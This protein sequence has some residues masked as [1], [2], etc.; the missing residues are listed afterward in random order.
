MNKKQEIEKKSKKKTNLT[1]PLDNATIA[2]INTL[3]SRY[4]TFRCELVRHMINYAIRSEQFVE[5][6]NKLYGCSCENYKKQ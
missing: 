2:G 5:T 3:V 1:V 4:K 6:M